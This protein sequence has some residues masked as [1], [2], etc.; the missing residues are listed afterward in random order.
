MKLKFKAL[1]YHGG[2]PAVLAFREV[3]SLYNTAFFMMRLMLLLNHD[4]TFTRNITANLLVDVLFI[5]EFV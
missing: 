4:L 2:E 1:Q 3:M 5:K